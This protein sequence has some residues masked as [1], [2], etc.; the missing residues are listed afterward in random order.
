MAFDLNSFDKLSQAGLTQML[1]LWGYVSSTD[2]IATIAAANYFDDLSDRVSIGDYIYMR[3]SDGSNL[4]AITATTPHVTVA[5][6]PDVVTPGSIATADLANNAV[7]LGKLASGITPSHI[8]KYAGTFTTA[9]GSASQAITVTGALNT[10]LAFAQLKTAGATPRTLLTAIAAAN[11]VN[12]VFSG[13]P[14]ADHVVCYQVL[15]AAS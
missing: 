15:R 1:T 3:G 10:D 9:A 12:L 7:T 2:A 13:D 11:A 8:V 14:L 4:A 5:L 6:N